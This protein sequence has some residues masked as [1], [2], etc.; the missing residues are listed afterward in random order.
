[1]TEVTF[2]APLLGWTG[3]ENMLATYCELP[4]AVGK[5]V[6]DHEIHQRIL[7]G[8]RR[9]F[10]SV[11]VEATIGDSTWST[12]LFKQKSGV[13]FLPVKAAVRRVEGLEEGDEVT[14][15]MTLL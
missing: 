11:K 3:S 7:T 15:T 14:A 6:A 4:E 9:G 5:Q 8:K 12:S 13:W 1:M 10:G 2:T